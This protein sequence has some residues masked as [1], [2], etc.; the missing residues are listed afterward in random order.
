[1]KEELCTSLFCSHKESLRFVFPSAINPSL[2]LWTCVE[3]WKFRAGL[4]KAYL[5]R[6]W[7]EAG[8]E[9][10]ASFLFSESR[11]SRLLE[12][13]QKAKKKWKPISL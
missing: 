1:M 13:S 10:E 5:E 7:K 9:K 3:E 11:H 8:Y 2:S 6:S 12:G 4:P